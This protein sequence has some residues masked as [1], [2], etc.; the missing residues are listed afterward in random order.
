[1]KGVIKMAGSKLFNNSTITDLANNFINIDTLCD[2]LT[3]TQKTIG[4]KT[5]FESTDEFSQPVQKVDEENVEP[6]DR[7]SV[8]K[9]LNPT[10]DWLDCNINYY[11][12]DDDYEDED[13]NEPFVCDLCDALGY[14]LKYRPEICDKCRKCETCMEYVHDEC[15]GC[16]YSIYRD[17]KYYRDKLPESELI[18]E[19]DIDTMEQFKFGCTGGCRR[20]IQPFSRY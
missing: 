11:D 13:D 6:M 5:I 2:V 9:M 20:Q 10:G 19:D 7:E 8:M 12:S 4:V 3:T 16:E 15:S 14:G 17:G 1:M 18:D